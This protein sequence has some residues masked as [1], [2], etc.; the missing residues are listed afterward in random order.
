MPPVLK[1]QQVIKGLEVNGFQ[2]VKQKG[3]HRKYK[4]AGRTV[5][6]PMHYEL[7][8]GTLSSILEQAGLTLEE[9][10]KNI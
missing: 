2:F 3:S 4:K 5:I 8:K 10:L 1:P 7:A 6:V 9:L